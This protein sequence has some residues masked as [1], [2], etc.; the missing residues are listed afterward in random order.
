MKCCM[1]MCNQTYKSNTNRVGGTHEWDVVWQ[2]V[3]K[4]HKS[5]TNMV[6]GVHEWSVLWKLEQ[7]NEGT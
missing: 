1:T 7:G 4:T 5:I 2:C 6:G 3:I